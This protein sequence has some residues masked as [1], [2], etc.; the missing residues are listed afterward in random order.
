MNGSIAMSADWEGFVR[1]C[2][3]PQHLPDGIEEMH[4]QTWPR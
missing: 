2:V 3:Q 1:N 4:E